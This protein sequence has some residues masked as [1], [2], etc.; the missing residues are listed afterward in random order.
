MAFAPSLPLF[1]VPSASSSTLSIADW[2]RASIPTTLGPSDWLTLSTALSTPLPSQRFLSPSRS[3]SAS[4]SPVE[5]PLGTAARPWPE[6]VWTSTSTV[7]FPRESRIA[8]ARTALISLMMGAVVAQPPT[9]GES[10][11]PDRWIT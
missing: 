2:S 5:A 3:S 10:P 11:S 8:R 4:C 9:A 6:S 7:G 1:G